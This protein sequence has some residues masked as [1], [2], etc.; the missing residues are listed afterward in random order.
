MTHIWYF[1]APNYAK[2]QLYMLL[3]AM[4]LSYMGFIFPQLSCFYE[5]VFS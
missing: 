1:I 2:V 4:R 3:V 5:Q